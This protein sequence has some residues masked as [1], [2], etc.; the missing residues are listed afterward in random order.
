MNRENWRRGLNSNEGNNRP[1]ILASS[2]SSSVSSYY[3]QN[4]SSAL[5]SL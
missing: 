2:L 4:T 3:G 5:L 1:Y